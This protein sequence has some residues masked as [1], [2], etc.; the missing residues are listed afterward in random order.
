MSESISYVGLDVHKAFIQVALLQPGPETPLEWKVPYTPAKVAGM[1]RKLGRLCD[2]PIELCYEAGPTGYDLQR[3]LNKEARMRCR[4]IA[5]SLIPHKAGERVKT[6]R[7]DARKLAE[8]LRAGL[9]TEVQQPTVE[10]EARREL[11]RARAAAKDDE[12]RARQR[13]SKFLLRQGRRFTEGKQAWTGKYMRWLE[14][15]RFEP[16]W[17]QTTFDALLRA[18]TQASDRVSELD[19][20]VE[21]AAQDEAVREP[22]AL[23]RCFKGIDTI[24]AMGLVTE[25]YDFHR[26]DSPRRLMAFVGIGRCQGSCREKMDHQAALWELQMWVF[27]RSGLR[28]TSLRGFHERVTP[29][30]RF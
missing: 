19:R 28:C 8:Y 17:L 6:D 22:V 11:W 27:T 29:V 12:K 26:F 3:K 21:A 30:Q 25:L 9:L 18:L 14:R 24:T 20:A 10:D 2:G 16:A 15:Q 23:L 13:L 7:R 4:V 1:V 5:P